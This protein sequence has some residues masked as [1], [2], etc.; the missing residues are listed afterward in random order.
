MLKIHGYQ[1]SINVR[2]VLWLCSELGL[3]YQLEEWGIPARPVA[4]LVFRKMNPVA[5]VPVIDDA[6][7]ILWESNTILRYLAASRGA[8][9]LL[10]EDAGP[11]AQIEKWMDWQVSD[12]NNTWRFAFQGLV[13]R[14]ADYQDGA[15][16]ARSMAA[17][18][19]AA[20]VID[21]E[22]AK[23]GGH[24]CGPQF[25]LADI[26]IG[27]SIHRWVS[28]PADK[29]Q[30]VNVKGYYDRLCARAGFRVFGRDGGP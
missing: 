30:L 9:A 1:A 12:F 2:K 16:I 25:T 26:P 13:R 27:L 7:F 20:Q 3:A 5:M 8:T 17:F 11:R 23:T 28:M 10:P 22:L 15:A 18:N 4:S 29:P 24:I 21:A 6:G 19:E 14:K